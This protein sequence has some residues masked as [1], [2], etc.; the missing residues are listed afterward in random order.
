MGAEAGFCDS[1]DTGAKIILSWEM[2][3]RDKAMRQKKREG[4]NEPVLQGQRA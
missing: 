2:G 4:K 1:A 3:F